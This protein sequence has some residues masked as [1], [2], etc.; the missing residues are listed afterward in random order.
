MK[1]DTLYQFVCFATNLNI[2]VF[3]PEWERFAKKLKGKKNEPGL[4]QQAADS[5]A[6]YRY[7]SQHEW[8]DHDFNFK[9]MGDRKSEHFP[10]HPVRVVQIG[11]YAPMKPG[12]RFTAEDNQVRLIAFL[13][14]NN[15]DIDFYQT[16]PF[17]QHFE[18]YQA[19]YESCHYGYVVELFVQEEDA[20]ELL[21]Q[22][23]QRPGLE[24]G[25]Y[26]ESLVVH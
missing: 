19:Y 12:K 3:S 22:L 8:P 14:H 26:R 25:I 5:K 23:N 17:V 24:A 18:L 16:L 2:D 7:V 1:K 6:R 13:G 4:Q 20:E 9:F 11:G 15:T 10:D 21:T